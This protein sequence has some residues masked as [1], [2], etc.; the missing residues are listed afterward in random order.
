MSSRYL[1]TCSLVIPNILAMSISIQG[2]LAC[3]MQ[4]CK[5]NHM[6]M[7]NTEDIERFQYDSHIP[8][9]R[10]LF[11]FF[12]FQKNLPNARNSMLFTTLYF[13]R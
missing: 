8:T 3:L 10:Y 6:E 11:L 7:E 2:T 9:S 12:L 4:A 5:L 1:R 13:F